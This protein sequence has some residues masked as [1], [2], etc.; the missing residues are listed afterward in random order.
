MWRASVSVNVTIFGLFSCRPGGVPVSLPSTS[1]S[2][3]QLLALE[4]G[5]RLALQALHGFA[6]GVQVLEAAVHRGKTHVGHRVEFLE[7]VHDPFADAP[8]G[9]LALAGGDELVADAPDRLFDLV[10]VHRAFFKRARHTAAQFILVEFLA[11]AVGLDDLRQLEFGTLKG[12]EA[13]ATNFALAPP[14]HAVAVFRQARVDHAGFR[15][16]NRTDNA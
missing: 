13:L 10:G 6:E 4:I 8:R 2:S 14:A 5:A 15:R 9:N 16:R 3:F 7:F 12:G 1:G 11:P